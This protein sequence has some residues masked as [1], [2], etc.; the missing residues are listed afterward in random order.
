MAQQINCLN[1]WQNNK[2]TCS[3]NCR[4]NNSIE[5]CSNEMVRTSF[6]YS[7]YDDCVSK[8]S[9]KATGCI[10]D[11]YNNP[12]T[13]LATDNCYSMTNTYI[14]SLNSLLDKYCK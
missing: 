4:I 12:V 5:I 10:D 11:C 3:E 7:S 2:K 6:G 13:K 14:Q 1:Q 8:R 9:E